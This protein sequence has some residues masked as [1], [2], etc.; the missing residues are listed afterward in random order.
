MT[1]VRKTTKTVYLCMQQQRNVTAHS[2]YGSHWC[3]LESQC[4]A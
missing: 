1:Q 4:P 3:P 2:T